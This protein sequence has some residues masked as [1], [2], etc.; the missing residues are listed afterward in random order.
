MNKFR[1][2]INFWIGGLVGVIFL[3]YLVTGFVDFV[4]NIQG[5]L[6]W[7]QNNQQFQ[8]FLRTFF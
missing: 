8:A 7:L 5:V 4:F 3:N 6:D 2:F 1:G